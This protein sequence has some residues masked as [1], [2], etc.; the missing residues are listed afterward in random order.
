MSKLAEAE[1]NDSFEEKKKDTF[2]IP[3]LLLER[4]AQKKKEYEERE[5][6]DLKDIEMSREEI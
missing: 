4:E 2:E 3:K 1:E 6:A 5:A